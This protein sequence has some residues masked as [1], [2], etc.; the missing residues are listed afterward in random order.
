MGRDNSTVPGKN[1]KLY[2]QIAEYIA[3]MIENKT[4][5]VGERIPSVRKMST[6]KRVSVTTVLQAYELLESQGLLEAK[7]QSGYYVDHGLLNLYL[8]LKFL[9]LEVIPQRSVLMN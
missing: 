5:R 6:Q 1:R 9:P 4:Y 2:E 7:P 3:K 8:H